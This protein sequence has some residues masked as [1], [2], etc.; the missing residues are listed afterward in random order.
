MA[1]HKIFIAGFGGQGVMLIGQMIASAGMLDNKEVTFLPSYGPEMRGGTAN[2]TVIVS[3]NPISCPIVDHPTCL[4]VMNEPSLVKF[5]EKVA[6]GGVIFVNTSLIKQKVQRNDVK[7]YYVDAGETAKSLENERAANI[8]MLGAV[9][10]QMGLTNIESI[11]K[12][13]EEVFSGRKAHLLSV[14]K[15]A[16]NAWKEE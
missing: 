5:E 2:C 15:K 12:V 9:I 8:V 7:V 16:L 1:T 6:P 4:V 13:L 14:N 11:E 3:D 10:R